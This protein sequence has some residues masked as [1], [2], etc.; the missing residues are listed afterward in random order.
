LKVLK[1]PCKGII[2]TSES[3]KKHVFY[4]LSVG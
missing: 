2:L 1:N 4:E 3:Q